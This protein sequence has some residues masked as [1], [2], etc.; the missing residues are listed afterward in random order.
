MTKYQYQ[1]N[2]EFRGSVRGINRHI[3]SGDIL[4][5]EDIKYFLH[6]Y[7]DR[8]SLIEGPDE[9][10]E[11]IKKPDISNNESDILKILTEQSQKLNDLMEVVKNSKGNTVIYT[12]ED[13]TTTRQNTIEMQ[14][15]PLVNLLKVD[16][17]DIISQGSVGEIKSE[18]IS[19]KDKI[20]RLKERLENVNS[21]K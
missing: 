19:V 7:P 15:S 12:E 16:T 3:K 17:S 21:K 13:R 5:P 14:D 4:N 9:I 1:Y 20:K 6:H 10:I 11:E 2:K 8:I 18:G